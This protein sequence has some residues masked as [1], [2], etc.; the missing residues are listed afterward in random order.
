MTTRVYRDTW[1]FKAFTLTIPLMACLAVP[2]SARSSVADGT[3]PRCLQC[4]DCGGEQAS[5]RVVSLRIYNQPPLSDAKVNRIF[6]ITNR[7]WSAYGVNFK[8]SESAEAITVVVSA[9]AASGPVDFRPTV[10][11]DTLFTSG[12]ATPYIHLWPANAE[13][14]AIDSEI[15][16]RP[17]MSLSMNERDNV[18]VQMLGVALAHELAHYLLDT[19]QHSSAGLLRS[20][21]G[22]N[23]LAFPNP[24]HLRL[25]H[26]QQQV[27]CLQS[28]RL[29]AAGSSGG[30][31][32]PAGRDTLLA[33]EMA[34][35]MRRESR[36]SVRPLGA[37]G[38]E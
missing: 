36:G 34:E 35:W 25:S 6:D 32:T 2:L 38:G 15:H 33:P 37:P 1:L 22:V 4:S 13:A 23:D 14:L 12:H 3:V 16:G 11:G 7:I 18:L 24:A 9:R 10:L 20:I 17:F 28:R 30:S 19:S 29:D 27:I 8:R 31:R 26:D 5:P 21:I